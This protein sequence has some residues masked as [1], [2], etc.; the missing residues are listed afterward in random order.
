MVLDYA[1]ANT[2]WMYLLTHAVVSLAFAIR[3]L[4]RDMAGAFKN[5]VSAAFALGLDASW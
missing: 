2:G 5:S 4:D 1:E 3:N